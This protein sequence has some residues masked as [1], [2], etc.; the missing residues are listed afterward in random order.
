MLIFSVGK[1][2]YWVGNFGQW[3]GLTHWVWANAHP[4]KLLSTSLLA[5]AKI[6]QKFKGQFGIWALGIVFFL[7]GGEGAIAQ[8]TCLILTPGS[9]DWKQP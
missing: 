3:S 6:S 9:Y 1:I 5:G 2:I 7:G 8:R 4:V